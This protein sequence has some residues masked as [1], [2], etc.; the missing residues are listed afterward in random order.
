MIKKPFIKKK[1]RSKTKSIKT[2]A[3]LTIQR[4]SS[5]TLFHAQC[6]NHSGFIVSAGIIGLKGA[7]RSSVYAARQTTLFFSNKLKEKGIDSAFIFFKG[8]G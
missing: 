2:T 4:T 7:R 1:K 8:F 6:I 3:N 5:N